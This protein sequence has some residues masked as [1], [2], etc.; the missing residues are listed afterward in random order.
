MTGAV[1]LL[2]WLCIAGD[3]CAA[4]DDPTGPPG[5]THWKS[6]ADCEFGYAL[7]TSKNPVPGGEIFV[8]RHT[9]SVEGRDL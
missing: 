6:L 2:S 9:C 8:R 4:A 5:V 1:I 3:A 7:Y